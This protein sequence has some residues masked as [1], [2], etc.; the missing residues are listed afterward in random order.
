[1][2]KQWCGG[3]GGKERGK[4]MILPPGTVTR[5]LDRE[6]ARENE[7]RVQRDNKQHY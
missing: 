3:H 5:D 6:P 1:M 2:K 4:S 7:T